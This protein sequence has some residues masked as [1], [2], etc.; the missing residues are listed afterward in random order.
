VPCNL[1][2]AIAGLKSYAEAYYCTVWS[3]QVA[4]KTGSCATE[5]YEPRQV[6]EEATVSKHFRVP[7]GYLVRAGCTGAVCNGVSRVGVRPFK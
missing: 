1:Q 3:V 4:K 6:R 7:Q 2:S 5:I